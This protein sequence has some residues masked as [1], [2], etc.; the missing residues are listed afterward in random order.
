MKSLKS[1]L[2]LF[3]VTFLLASAFT[4]AAGTDPQTTA[5]V[6][7][8]INTSFYLL[9]SFNIIPMPKGILG[10][11][12]G[13]PGVSA[14]DGG[15]GIQVISTE[16]DRAIHL[17]N[18]LKAEY[19]GKDLVPGYLRLE[20]VVTNNSGVLKFPT[21]TGDSNLVYATEQRLGRNDA[22]IVAD[23]GVF[24]LKQDVAN[25]KTNGLPVSYPN[26]TTFGAAAAADLM[27]IFAAGKL[28]V[29]IDKKRWLPDIDCL[30]FLQMPQVQQS[31]GTNYDEWNL[32]KA[33]KHC[34]PQFVIN[35]N[36]SNEI[37]IEY[38]TYAGFAGGTPVVAGNEHRVVLYLHGWYV[39]DGNSKSSS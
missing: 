36:G 22:F 38:P 30:R 29:E 10:D 8:T 26:I 12:V 32:S 15:P 14:P 34:T 27:T 25:K 5:L 4:F 37:K 35:G 18:S 16:R 17:N 28:N 13:I 7:G 6:I 2:S 21:Y 39:A 23:Y 33:L 20:A 11:F 24:L 19:A 9:T 3:V 1:I 31:A